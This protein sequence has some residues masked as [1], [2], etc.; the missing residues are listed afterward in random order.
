VRTGRA[1]ASLLD[2]IRVIYYGAPTPLSQVATVNV[3]DARTI[4]IQPWEKNLI[5][6]IEKAILQSG[7]GLNPTNDGIVV[8]VPIPPL[9]EERRRDIVKMC[10]KDAEESKVAVRNIRRDQM[11]ALKKAEKEEHFSEDERIRAEEEVQKVTDKHV[12]MVDEIL[13][14]KEKEIMEV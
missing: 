3:P 1:S 4:V 8:R 11:E 10:K 7:L 6:D 12:K 9:N 13:A 5:G 14:K 2:D